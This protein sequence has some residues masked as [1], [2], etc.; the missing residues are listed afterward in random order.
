MISTNNILLD[1]V[2]TREGRRQLALGTSNLVQGFILADDEVD[3]SILTQYGNTVGKE[4]IGTAAIPAKFLDSFGARKTYLKELEARK[5]S[6]DWAKPKE[7][8]QQQLV[9][10]QMKA[11]MGK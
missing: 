9:A 6:S 3:Y 10:S 5:R 2:L 4:K 1:A 8:I 7:V 11:A